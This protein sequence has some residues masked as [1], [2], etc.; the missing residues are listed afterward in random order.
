MRELTAAAILDPRVRR[1]SEFVVHDALPGDRIG[2]AHEIFRFLE[3]RLEF[4]RDPT[5]T[6][7]LQSP[8]TLI[9]RIDRLGWAAGNCANHSMMAATLGHEVRLP[10]VWVLAG[11]APG[12][13]EHIYCAMRLDGL[14]LNAPVGDVLN[15]LLSLDTG[16]PWNHAPAFGRHVNAVSFRVVPALVGF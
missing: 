4:R 11:M 1:A 5:T 14:E 15:D 13:F 10:L 2:E 9:E 8:V 7:F 3:R 12:E 16:S 6:Q